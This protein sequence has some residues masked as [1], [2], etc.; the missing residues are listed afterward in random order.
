MFSHSCVL[1]HLAL[2]SCDD[3]ILRDHSSR[4]RTKVVLEYVFFFYC[5]DMVSYDIN[6]IDWDVIAFLYLFLIL[7]KFFCSLPFLPFLVFSV[8]MTF[9]IPVCNAF[10][11]AVFLKYHGYKMA[12]L[13]FHSTLK[14][15]LLCNSLEYDK[16]LFNLVIPVIDSN[17]KPDIRKSLHDLWNEC[18]NHSSICWPKFLYI[19]RICPCFLVD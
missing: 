13:H 3:F 4:R 9:E 5:W 15:F 11:S 7:K 8:L 1:V 10:I 19:I 2:E 16:D 12:G 18:A 6:F 17:V 14:L